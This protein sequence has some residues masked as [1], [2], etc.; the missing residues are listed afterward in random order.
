MD[1]E[2]L[3]YYASKLMFDMKDEEYDT[4]SKEFDIFLKQMDLISKIDHLSEV[5]PMTFPYEIG[6]AKLREDEAKET[7]TIEEVLKNAESVKNR[8]VKVPKVVGE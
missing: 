5:K 6:V 7:L 1:K 4:L 3:K 2:K 8:E